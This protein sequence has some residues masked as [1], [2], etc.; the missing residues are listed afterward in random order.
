MSDI[1]S[2][3]DFLLD[4]LSGGPAVHE[5][6]VFL[7]VLCIMT[8]VGVGLFLIY[9]FFTIS[10]M[11]AMESSF[12]NLDPDMANDFDNSL[13]NVYRWSKIN[14]IISIIGN[15]LCL[16]GAILMFLLKR[17]GFFIYLVG[18]IAPLV[19]GFFFFQSIG[20]NFI[21]FQAIYFGLTAIFPVGFIILY[22]LNYKHLR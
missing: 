16:G 3:D 5:R 13:G 20:S 1:L 8:F 4:D 10:T 2:D 19:A 22:S 9:N 15:L 11:S 21:E 12:K 18:Q 17:V 6:P 7:T 14:I